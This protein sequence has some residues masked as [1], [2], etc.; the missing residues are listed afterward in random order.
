MQLSKNL[1]C[2]CVDLDR[3]DRL[4]ARKV[5]R[6]LWDSLIEIFTDQTSSSSNKRSNQDQMGS[7]N[8]SDLSHNSAPL[9]LNSYQASIAKDSQNLINRESLRTFALTLK[10]SLISNILT[11]LL[12]TI[13]NIGESMVNNEIFS[14]FRFLWPSSIA[15]SSSLNINSVLDLMNS[16]LA[17]YTINMSSFSPYSLRTNADICLAA[18]NYFDSFK[19]Y[20]QIFVC[21]TKYFFKRYDS[22]AAAASAAASSKKSVDVNFEDFFEK[23][24]KSMIKCCIQLN[25]HTHAALLSQMLENNNEYL[26]VFRVLQDRT[27]LTLDEMDSVYSCLWDINLLEFFSYLNASRGQ[28]DRRNK[29]LKLCASKCLN[30]ANP[31]EIFERTV[32]A[33]KKSL[34]LKLVKY[35]IVI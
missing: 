19:F 22:A 17:N 26:A 35:Y 12:S 1:S 10:N 31:G 27:I 15:N 9:N 34:F 13:Y 5:G 21:E 16:I 14:E 25:K 30:S 4:V 29:C 28:I 18:A 24:L 6:E 23:T 20:L 2:L 11:S 3:G 33:K 7:N 32:D 8:F